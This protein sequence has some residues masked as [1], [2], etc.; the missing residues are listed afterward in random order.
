MTSRRLE[1]L[2][3][4]LR[5]PK[6]ELAGAALQYF[7]RGVSYHAGVLVSLVAVLVMANFLVI[8]SFA[9]SPLVY[10]SVPAVLVIFMVW[11]GRHDIL[12]GVK[13]RPFW[14]QSLANVNTGIAE[15]RWQ[16]KSSREQGRDTRTIE[17]NLSSLETMKSRI[18]KT[19]GIVPTS[20]PKEKVSRIL[21]SADRRVTFDERY[22]RFSFHGKDVRLVADF[23][24]GGKLD[25]QAPVSVPEEYP[26]VET[27]YCIVEAFNERGVYSRVNP[28]GKVVIDI[29]AN[30]GDT[31]IAFALRG[32]EHV[33][34]FEPNTYLFKRM[35]ENVK[36]NNLEGKITEFHAACGAAG[37]LVVSDEFK[38]TRGSTLEESIG[39]GRTIDSYSLARIA[40]LIQGPERPVLLKVDC[41]GCEDRLIGDA[42]IEALK[43][44]TEVYLEYHYGY[45]HLKQKLQS[46]GFECEI[47]AP[48]QPH[49]NAYYGKRMEVGLLHAVRKT[50]T[51]R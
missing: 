23:E 12:L 38:A 3:Q 28:G 42:P 9:A 44:I 33:Y 31:A 47:I 29:G 37:Q 16:L 19:L 15:A 21:R 51:G 48:P 50:E 17:S 40:S 45:E 4:L 6:T 27:A 13:D 24:R 39:E 49:Y 18:E 14:E 20:A 2:R 26:A 1:Y 7:V 11:I 34:S 10:L 25:E 35:T 41:E 8:L 5:Q 36:L 46:A 22:F 30:V 32:A 43:K